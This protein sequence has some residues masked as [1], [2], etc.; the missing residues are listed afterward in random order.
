VPYG[1]RFSPWPA[2]A[3][4]IPPA[5]PK[6]PTC[7]PPEVT[8]PLNATLVRALDEA[9][10]SRALTAATTALMAELALV[11][12]TLAAPLAPVLDHLRVAS[13]PS[14]PSQAA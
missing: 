3:S 13:N 1:A 10:L 9:E 7:F 8:A 11:D 14:P 6:A 4:V 5:T 2:F 12:A